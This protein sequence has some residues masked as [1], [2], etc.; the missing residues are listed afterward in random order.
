MAKVIIY[1]QENGSVAVCYPSGELPIEEVLVKDCP[2]GAIIVDEDILPK[3]N[4]N[5]FFEAWELNGSTISVNINK[6]REMAS[7]ELNS[8]ARSEASHRMINSASGIANK[9]S[10]TDWIAVL[11]SARS[12]INI[13]ENTDTLVSAIDAVQTIIKDNK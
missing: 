8:L 12:S 2:Q 4:D 11:T 5:F 3:G 9:L 1:S 13:A 10:D 7:I 6:A